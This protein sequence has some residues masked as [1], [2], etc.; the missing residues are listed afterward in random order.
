MAPPGVEVV[1]GGGLLSD[2]AVLRAHLFAKL[3][4][5]D[6][7]QDLG[8]GYP[9]TLCLTAVA[10][11]TSPRLSARPPTSSIHTEAPFGGGFDGATRG[12]PLGEPFGE[13]TGGIAVLA[14]GAHRFRRERA[15]RTA[16]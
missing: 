12:G 4:E 1:F 9:P 3:I 6:Q 14:Q 2:L 15:V 5:I 7:L 13:M 16:A 11:T 8:H 10:K